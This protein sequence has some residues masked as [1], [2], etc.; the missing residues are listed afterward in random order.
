[1]TKKKKNRKGFTLIEL[2]AV[3]VIL[4]VVM[5]VTIPSVLNAMKTARV[6]QFQNAADTVADWLQKEYELSGMDSADQ[7]YYD[8]L[9]SCDYIAGA[10][11]VEDEFIN[12]YEFIRGSGAL[13]GCPLTEEV[14]ESAGLNVKDIGTCKYAE[15]D[16]CEGPADEG[17]SDYTFA[18]YIEDS[19]RICVVLNS[20]PDTSAFATGKSGHFSRYAYSTGCEGF[21]ILDR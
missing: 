9:D 4:A 8:W 1:M 12:V 2:L 18:H 17:V 6:K 10:E 13:T 20:G 19:N 11:G 5:V 7:V 14:I 3:I 16:S 21:G 15:Y